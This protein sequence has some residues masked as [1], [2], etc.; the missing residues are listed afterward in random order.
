[1]RDD[2]TVEEY[3]HARNIERHQAISKLFPKR[4]KS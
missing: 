2:P 4:K 1:M 3:A